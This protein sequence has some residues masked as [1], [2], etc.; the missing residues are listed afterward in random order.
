MSAPPNPATARKPRRFDPRAQLTR[1]FFHNF[2][3]LL[4]VA[5]SV[6]EAGLL[7][8]V[9]S[10]LRV[11]PSAVYLLASVALFGL[12]GWLGANGRQRPQIR[13][14][15]GALPRLYYAVA[16]GSLFGF[17]F[18]VADATLW[19]SAK[20]VLGAIPAGATTVGRV[21]SLGFGIDSM[22]RWLA[23][24]GIATIA[25]SFVYGYSIG[26][27]RLKVRRVHVPLR[28][29]PAAWDGL[30]IAQISDIHVGQ[31]L[32]P[33]QLQQFITRVNDLQPDIICI[34]GDIADSPH[35]DM[36]AFFPI[37]AGLRARHAVFAILGNHDHYAGPERVVAAL[38]RHT[39]FTVLR[40]SSTSL[41]L[42][43]HRF[44]VIGLDDRGRDW[45]RGVVEAPYLDQALAEVDGAGAV[46]LLCHRPDLFPYAAGAGVDLMLSGHTHGGQIGIPWLKGRTRNLA[47]FITRFDRGLFER[48]GKY[49]YVNCGL[50]VTGQRVRLSTPR[51]IT[52][53]ELSAG[54]DVS[55]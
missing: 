52:L 11:L 28:H 49:L 51:E 37:L 1:W 40:D 43:G 23:N 33:Q 4:L 12:N 39:S 10:S 34:T 27:R 42:R 8:W 15:V 54:A 48:D 16:L 35:A 22:F 55:A 24:A 9:T 41:D 50:G 2:F 3:A 17:A 26:Q 7:W 14:R 36:D 46:L 6:A 38:Q 32:E 30:K 47:Q 19:L 44:A 31:N 18:L 21:A 5:I 20:L 25:L 45:A 53:I 29:A 13:S